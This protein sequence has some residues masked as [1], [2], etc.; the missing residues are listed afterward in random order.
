[1]ANKSARLMMEALYGKGCMF[2][3][4]HIAERIKQMGGIRTYKQFVGMQH[5]KMKKIKR[6]EE[7]MTF[8]HLKH[9]AD[10]GPTS[11]ENGA[12]VNE[13]AHRYIHS[14]P[15]EQEEVVNNML[16]DYKN[17][18]TLN[19]GIMIPTEDGL[20]VQPFQMSLSFDFNKDDEEYE[21]IP[22]YDTAREDKE[23]HFNRAKVKR[24]TQKQMAE[25]L[26][27]YYYGRNEDDELD[28][29]TEDR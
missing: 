19:G 7:T 15:R 10:G 26:Y 20:D 25:D 21:V 24:E 23:K 9:Q 27:D 22:V 12:V 14:L 16:R 4:A 18:F 11:V 5:Y 2:Q 17:Q 8:H 6:L 1:M 3:K 29:E 13:F 28:R